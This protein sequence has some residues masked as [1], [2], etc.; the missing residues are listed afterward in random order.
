MNRASSLFAS[1]FRL[2]SFAWATLEL[3]RRTCTLQGE[4]QSRLR[5]MGDSGNAELIRRFPHWRIWL[6]EPDLAPHRLSL[7]P[8]LAD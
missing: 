6:A 5:D 8:V 7:Y 2:P 4:I 1:F 3:A